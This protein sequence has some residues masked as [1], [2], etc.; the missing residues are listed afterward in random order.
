M[1]TTSP[2]SGLS[3]KRRFKAQVSHIETLLEA[4]PS[5]SLLIDRKSERIILANT[6]VV[7]LT[8][9]TRA[10]LAG[11][12]LASLLPSLPDL[13]FHPQSASIST[14][15]LHRT[16]PGLQVYATLNTPD[17]SDHVSILSLETVAQVEEHEA[18]KHRDTARTEAFSLLAKSFQQPDLASAYA[19]AVKAGGMLL[20]RGILAIYHTSGPEFQLNLQAAHGPAE[21]L[22]QELPSHEM[23]VLKSPQI[24]MANKRAVSGI[25]RA[26]RSAQLAMVASVP[27]GEE[28]A[29]IG[30]LVAASEQVIQ[31]DEIMPLMQTLADSITALF[32]SFSLSTNLS[33]QLEEANRTKALG[34][35]V[36]ESMQEGMVILSTDLRIAGLNP[37]AEAILGYA[38]REI[39][40]WP[41]QNVL[42]GAD[43]II[44][45]FV[46]VDSSSEEYSLKNV[47]LYRRN[48]HSF[49]ANVRAIPIA[50]QG[51][52]VY[53]VILIQ[54]LSQEEQYRLR[55]QHLEQRA[56]MGEVSAIFAHEVRNPIN[57]ISTGLQ[58]MSMTLPEADPNQEVLERLQNDCTRLLDLT[59][60]TLTFVRPMEYK[61]EPIAL[62]ESLP[63]LLERWRSHLNRVNIQAEIQVDPN[64]PLILG[65]QRALEQV[66]NNLIG[67]AIQA[68]T[69]TGGSLRIKVRKITTAENM[70][71]VEV[72][73]SDTGSGIPDEIK[74]KVF[75]PFFT[76]NPN[77]TGLGLPISKQIITAHRGSMQL[78]SVPGGTSFQILLP[79]ANS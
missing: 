39:K 19:M 12:S 4:L 20:G 33:Q 37:S 36:Q 66:W 78:I 56:L 61:M 49:L 43:H 79:T 9:F 32:Q 15:L 5:P 62:Q 29:K 10:E 42:I 23:M 18:R 59:K 14:T 52:L 13:L 24:W 25:H 28:K 67:N 44:P 7:E 57:N 38:N 47:R 55:N 75:E 73:L 71:R 63:R 22:P 17:M 6:K 60:S 31:A 41:Y 70:P 40:G 34:A 30:V 2:L 64:T 58:L 77:G 11:R 54:D 46:F 16:G 27:L 51:H 21:M 76:T 8:A 3:L 45:P 26:A 50:H 35:A 72:V 74:D 48:G 69:K 65:D 1:N 53:L 68:M